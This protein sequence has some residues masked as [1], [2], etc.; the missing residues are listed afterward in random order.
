MISGDAVIELTVMEMTGS[1][2]NRSQ[3]SA[4]NHQKQGRSNYQNEDQDWNGSQE[5]RP[6]KNYRDT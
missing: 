6:I 4:L 3:V 2:H 5:A 1:K